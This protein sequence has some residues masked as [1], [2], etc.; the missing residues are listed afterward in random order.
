[1]VDGDKSPISLQVIANISIKSFIF[2]LSFGG[3]LTEST[4][5]IVVKSLFSSAMI[6]SK[7]QQ[8]NDANNSAMTADRNSGNYL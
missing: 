1:M 2:V 8:N 3:L 6:I 7:K 5:N 4:L